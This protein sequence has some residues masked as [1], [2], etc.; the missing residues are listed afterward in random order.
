VATN[1]SFTTVV[2]AKFIQSETSSPTISNNT[3]YS[4]PSNSPIHT[5]SS[6]NT[7]HITS[8]HLIYTTSNNPSHTASIEIQNHSEPPSLTL[9]AQEVIHPLSQGSLRSYV[10]ASEKTINSSALSSGSPE[11]PVVVVRDTGRSPESVPKNDVLPLRRVIPTYQPAQR[12]LEGESLPNTTL[13]PPITSLS[14]PILNSTSVSSSNLV[15]TTV[16]S[17]HPLVYVQVPTQS[18]RTLGG[19]A[20]SDELPTVSR[21]VVRPHPQLPQR[22]SQQKVEASVGVIV[23]PLKQIEPASVQQNPLPPQVSKRMRV[24]ATQP[25]HQSEATPLLFTS[26]SFKQ[27]TSPQLGTE[28]INL[29]SPFPEISVSN[30]S[31]TGTGRSIQT[32]G[33]SSTTPI[34]ITSTSATN[35]AAINREQASKVDIDAIANQ[36]ERKLMRRLVVE[37]ERRGQMT[38]KR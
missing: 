24:T 6:N 16:V 22:H 10:Q 34:T 20:D 3:I 19:I 27:A 1:S 18:R 26:P 4:T 5:T 2:Q 7:V 29:S 31:S 15:E 14:P 17:Q 37:R 9:Q 35:G 12:V 21:T 33:T 23:T 38:W 8:N 11:T 32:N 13:S 25:I 36:V 28:R 30:G